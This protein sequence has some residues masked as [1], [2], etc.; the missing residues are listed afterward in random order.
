MRYVLAFAIIFAGCSSKKDSPGGGSNDPEV[1]AQAL[2]EALDFPG[3]SVIEG[4][5]GEATDG[6][7]VQNLSLT[8]SKADDVTGPVIEPGGVL[9][10]PLSWSGGTI[11]GA[12]I[13]FGGGSYLH[14]PVDD[15]EGAQMT[16]TA[17]LQGTLSDNVCDNL[18]HTCHQLVCN[19]QLF[20]P[21][22]TSV[23]N[24]A[25]QQMVL[26]CTGGEGCDSVSTCDFNPNSA[27][28]PE[29]PTCLQDHCASETEAC[30]GGDWTSGDFSGSLC[31]DTRALRPTKPAS[32]TASRAPHPPTA[33]RVSRRMGSARPHTARPSAERAA[34]R[35]TEGH[36]MAASRWTVAPARVARCLPTAVRRCRRTTNQDAWPSSTRTSSS[37]ARTLCR[38]TKARGSARNRAAA[39]PGTRAPEHRTFRP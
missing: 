27:V 23:T 15:T 36:R 19:E 7:G 33:P 12:N 30:F 17:T 39:Q 8:D 11:G 29:C 35:P 37:H 28:D 38:G 25:V 24:A 4:S 32:R 18:G 34:S 31:G 9:D 1:V 3:A 22:G 14:V 10:V 2:V 5:L 26:D 6:V 21:D 13:D 16:G 20:L